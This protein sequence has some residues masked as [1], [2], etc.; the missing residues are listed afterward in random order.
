MGK[1]IVIE[2]TDGS[3]KSTQTGKLTQYLKARGLRVKQFHF[4]SG[5]GFYGRAINSFLKGDLGSAEEVDPYYVA[6]LFAR[7]RVQMADRVRKWI[8]E[9]DIVLMDRYA[10]SNVAYQCAKLDQKPKE[11]E[12]LYRW[13]VDM[14]F[15]SGEIPIP[16]LCLYL[17]VPRAFSERK[18][19]EERTGEDREYLEGGTD[20]HEQ[21]LSLQQGVA[22]VYRE[23]C[24]E[25]DEMVYVECGDASGEMLKSDEIHQKIVKLLEERRVL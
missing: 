5:E 1:F 19:T 15:A 14:E 7:D 4:P 11:R 9:Y 12:K 13:I 17:G 2:G 16:D 24:R 3:G 23:M 21:N 22:G 18:L 8:E 10:Y 25:F 20:I 6:F